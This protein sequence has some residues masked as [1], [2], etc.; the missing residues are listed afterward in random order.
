MQCSPYTCEIL[1]WMSRSPYSFRCQKTNNAFMLFFRRLHFTVSLLTKRMIAL[2]DWRMLLLAFSYVTYTQDPL[3]AGSELPRSCRN[4]SLLHT[5]G[6]CHRCAHSK[7]QLVSFL[8]PPAR[9]FFNAPYIFWGISN[10]RLK[11]KIFSKFQTKQAIHFKLWIEILWKNQSNKLKIMEVRKFTTVKFL[12]QEDL[13]VEDSIQSW[14][15]FQSD[16]LLKLMVKSIMDPHTH[17]ITT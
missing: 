3:A 7:L 12:K 15:K 5:H 16:W 11:N 1:R 9:L 6:Y 4:H 2:E 14:L 17:M 13:Y 10:T 8:T